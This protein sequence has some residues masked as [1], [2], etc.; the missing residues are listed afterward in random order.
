MPKDP[1]PPLTIRYNGIFD[2]DRLYAMVVDWAKMYNYFWLEKKH[3]HK[4]RNGSVEQELSWQA[5][6]EATEYIRL[7]VNI[8]IKMWDLK[9]V[10]LEVAG[11]KRL[12]SNARIEIKIS[13]KVEYDWQGF[14]EKNPKIIMRW[15]GKIYPLKTEIPDEYFIQ[16]YSKLVNLHSLMKQYFDMQSKRNPF[17]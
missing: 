10:E 14:A 1:L 7:I 11:R 4:V 9:E 5:T 17:S 6:R 16:L 8:D 3:V 2:F 12:L 15:L 13:G